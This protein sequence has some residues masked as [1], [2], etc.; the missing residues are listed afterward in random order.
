MTVT[1]MTGFARVDGMEAGYRWVWEVK[2][3]N[4]GADMRF[5]QPPGFDHIEAVAR[6]APAKYSRGNLSINLVLQRPKKV[7]ALEINR[8]VLEKMMALAAEFRGSREAVYVES[9]MGLRGVIEVVEEAT[10]AEELVTARMP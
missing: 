6:N 4:Q 2:S 5:R 9:L 3:V 7:P 10:E 1:S 8:D